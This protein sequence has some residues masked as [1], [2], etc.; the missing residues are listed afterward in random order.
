M[1][2]PTV[3]LQATN[4]GTAVNRRRKSLAA[5]SVAMLAGITPSIAEQLTLEEVVVTAQK[6]IQTLQE[7]PISVATLSGER[8]DAIFSDGSDILALGT[9]LPGLYA[10]SSNGRASPRFYIR[11]L[12]NSDFDLAASQPVSIIMDEVVMENVVLKSFPLF[13]VEQVE[14]IRGPQG[15]LFGR[16]TTAGIVKFD[17]R[18]PSEN[19]EGFFKV[20]MG[21]FGT[22]NLE[23]AIGGELTNGLTG[24]IAVLSQNRD[25]WID[26]GFTGKSDAMGGFEETAFRGKLLWEPSDTFSALL[27]YQDR[28]LDG[29][30][31]IFRGNI[32]TTGKNGLNSNFDRDKVFY[33]DGD[34]NPQG[35]DS[36][37]TTLKME[38]DLGAVTVT[39][40]SSYQEAES[41]SKGDI[42]GA[43]VYPDGSVVPGPVLFNAVTEDQADVEQLT[44]EIRVSSNSEG[45]MNWQLG[46][47]YFDGDLDVTTID[48]F[49]GATTV[50][51]ENTTWAVFAQTSYDVSD[52][53]TITG[54]VRYTD[55]EK[56]LTVGQQNTDGFALVIGAASVQ[57]YVPV[58]ES[59]D[60]VSWELSANYTLNENSSLFTRV[61]NGFRA[62]SIQARDIAFEGNPSVADSETINSFEVGYKADLLDDRARLN[63]GVFY[64]TIDDM[65][66]SAIGGANNGNSL[67]NADKGTGMGFEIDFEF[68][69]TANLML[70]A[71][72]GYADTEIDDSNLS[73]APC[74]SRF[75][76]NGCTVT[77]PINGNGEALIDGNPFQSAP[78]TTMNFSARY[79]MP[80]SSG[81][82]YFFTDWA[83][84]GETNMALYESVELNTDDQFEA[85]LRVGYINDKHGFEVA[86]FGRNIT[87]EENI[88][89]QIDFNNNTGFVNDPAMWG[90]DFKMSL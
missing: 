3:R 72:Y 84:Q 8:M 27:S 30:S 49:F 34:N 66:L 12:G 21:S 5:L 28:D 65:Q 4:T 1:T 31:S 54:G 22:Q 19:T 46:A 67:L 11:G 71:G 77:D 79:S 70:V 24:R 52:V 39:S 26:N 43:A 76:S 89:G 16:N 87:D 41:F 86:V 45:P 2:K 51:H 73:T 42:D 18:G 32:F 13:D 35:V 50:M 82:V 80:I 59:D 44:Q 68:A 83:Y 81:E 53:L 48:G 69:V 62:Q 9:R 61:A 29:T 33:D 55:D 10:E 15:T 63:V 23:A 40:I 56:D 88:K 17:T 7:V 85:G 25:D 37:G 6:R 74:G 36:S 75:T 60:Q 64:Y 58:N 78:E 14:A 57:S 20:T 90:V 38:W 47:F